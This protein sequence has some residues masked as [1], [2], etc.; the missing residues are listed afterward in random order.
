MN[1]GYIYNFNSY[2]PSMGR[3]VHVHQILSGLIK[4]GHT[5]HVLNLEQ[6]P[7]LMK[8][9]K[10]KEGL[11]HLYKNV[12]IL[13]I[14][15]DGEQI[16]SEI[17]S[18]EPYPDNLPIVWEINSPIS[19]FLIYIDQFKSRTGLNLRAKMDLRSKEMQRKKT[20]KTV[21]AAI[22]VSKEMQQYASKFLNIKKTYIIPNGSDPCIFSP[23]LKDKNLFTLPKENFIV[24]WSGNMELAWH[25]GLLVRNIAEKFLEIDKTV[26]FVFL[27][28]KKFFNFNLPEN[29]I[30][31]DDIPY[32]DVPK[33][34]ASSDVCLCLYRREP[35]CKWGFYLSSLKL[36][37]Y[38]SSACP[39]IASDAGQI[40]EVIKNGINGFLTNNKIEDII[41]K[42]I[43]LK[44]NTEKAKNIGMKAR[45]DIVKVYNWNNIAEKT[46]NIFREVIGE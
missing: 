15:L 41:E 1:I 12:D 22:C 44:S 11:Q 23:E 26:S 36:F 19:E 2:P 39:V 3:S 29:S 38:M 37:D 40:S 31:I 30:I 4:K 25:E 24:L 27:T 10:T 5:L 46:E 16:E 32:N 43:F 13:Y 34:F 7:D 35:W 9:P 17:F 33:Y 20:A 14:R 28:K 8:Y 45:E 42:L 21:K 18:I 6:M